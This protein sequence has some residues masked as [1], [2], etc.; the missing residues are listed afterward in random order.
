MT[1]ASQEAED[2]AVAL[3]TVSYI[4]YLFCFQKYDVWTLFNSSSKVNT[5]ILAFVFKLGFKIQHTNV[6][7]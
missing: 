1:V 7:A 4:Q 6:G 3:D 2:I 5:M